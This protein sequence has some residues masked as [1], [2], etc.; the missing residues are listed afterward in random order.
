[1]N[2]PDPALP[3]PTP[4]N[5]A[6][7]NRAH[8]RLVQFLNTFALG[9]HSHVSRLSL[10]FLDEAREI[11]RLDP[12]RD[13]TTVTMEQAQKRLAAW[14]AKNLGEEGQAPSKILANGYIALL[15]SR[16]YC[17]APKAFLEFPL[18]DDLR[19]SMRQTLLMAGPDLNVSSMT[20]RHLDYGPML[21]LARQTWHRW[22]GKS[23]TVAVLF[24]AGVYAIVYFM[25]VEAL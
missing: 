7:W 5:A 11:H 19:G 4:E 12:S 21:D 23:F 8:D 15:L 2:F 1:M 16:F 17:T 6:A 3:V 24:W 14:L 25:F 13:P 20:P 22:D 10:E 18:R 9:D